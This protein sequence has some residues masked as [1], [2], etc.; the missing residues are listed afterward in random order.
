V[1]SHGSLVII[2]LQ[3]NVLARRPNHEANVGTKIP[4]NYIPSDNSGHNKIISPLDGRLR[5]F[6]YEK[7]EAY[8]FIAV[9]SVDV[10]EL[11]AP[12]HQQLT[13]HVLIGVGGTLFIFLLLFYLVHQLNS[14]EAL[15]SQLDS[16]RNQ[17]EESSRAKSNFLAG[18]SHE[19]RTPLN[20][21]LGFS[22][23]ISKQYFGNQ[24]QAKYAEYAQDIY[25]SSK[26]M[27]SLIDDLID[28]TSIA[29]GHFELHLKPFFLPAVTEEC[30]ALMRERIR[31]SGVSVYSSIPQEFPK[32]FCDEK[33]IRQI[34]L[35]L[36]SNA[37]KFTPIDGRI[38]VAATINFEGEVKISVSD[39]G[40]GIPVAERDR[41]I[42]PFTRSRDKNLSQIEGTGLGLSI[43]KKL[44]EAHGGRLFIDDSDFGGA[45]LVIILPPS[46][47]S[48]SEAAKDS[49]K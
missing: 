20:A 24:A 16:A 41:L 3:G 30:I 36:I 8:N 28:V 40:P 47:I 31:E 34:L 37:I 7:S 23:I 27:L 21:I 2:D 44:A 19:L 9:A 48:L 35:N 33:A 6:G 29:S 14:H 17:A 11:N 39:S 15:L 25:G 10:N 22:E 5:Y 42:I 32:L 12:W 26:H 4:I 18:V 38:E 46:R 49:A 13:I 43:C 1:P 45:K